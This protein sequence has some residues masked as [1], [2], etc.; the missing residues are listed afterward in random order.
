MN[1]PIDVNIRINPNPPKTRYA[2]IDVPN[3]ESTTNQILGFIIDW[4]KLYN[5]LVNKWN[6]EKVFFYSGIQKED[7]AK[8]LEYKELENIGYIVNLKPFSIYK[9]RDEYIKLTCPEC[10]NEITH[11]ISRGVRWKSNCDVELS[12]D[13]TNHANTD[14]EYL[15]FTGDGD[16]EYL[17]RDVVG[18]G[19][20]T[21]I[22]SSAKKIKITPRYFISRFSTKLRNL[23]ATNRN[24]VIFKDINDWKM[25]IRKE[26]AE[27]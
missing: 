17:I 9:N 1:T 15:I 25:I 24:S 21:Y 6:C 11:K 19:V 10:N 8:A 14:V 22:V 2:F 26:I 16:F 20:K 12:V 23:I 13:A 5:H 7:I 18:K 27:V 3:T 4:H